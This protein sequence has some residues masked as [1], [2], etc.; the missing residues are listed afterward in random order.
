MSA[1]TLWGAVAES[2]LYHHMRPFLHRGWVVQ[3][4]ASVGKPVVHSSERDAAVHISIS[5][6]PYHYA[7]ENAERLGCCCRFRSAA[8][9]RCGTTGLIYSLYRCKT[10]SGSVKDHRIQLELS[11]LANPF[12]HQWLG[13]QSRMKRLRRSAT[14]LGRRSA[15]PSKYPVTMLC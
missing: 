14:S 11:V 3:R 12:V 1:S 15:A 6:R 4:Q 2:S 8:N 10:L 13:L 7:S 5:L 9:Q